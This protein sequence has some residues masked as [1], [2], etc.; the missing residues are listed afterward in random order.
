MP[1]LVGIS[2]LAT[3]FASWAFNGK[4]DKDEDK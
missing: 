1:L 3:Q 4:R 2:N